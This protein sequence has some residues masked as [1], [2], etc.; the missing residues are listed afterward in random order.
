MKAWLKAGQSDNDPQALIDMT[1][2]NG[3]RYNGLQVY[4][5]PVTSDINKYGGLEK[6]Y[7]WAFQGDER[8]EEKQAFTLWKGEKEF[9]D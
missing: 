9:L 3:H 6:L 2:T 4:S 8:K 5:I 7:F 1:D